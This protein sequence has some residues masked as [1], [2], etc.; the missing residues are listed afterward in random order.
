MSISSVGPAH[1]H[2]TNGITNKRRTDKTSVSEHIAVLD[3]HLASGRAEATG[4]TDT[5]H[6]RTPE[7][8]IQDVGSKLIYNAGIDPKLNWL[9]NPYKE[10]TDK[11]MQQFYKALEKVTGKHITKERKHAIQSFLQSIANGSN[12][13]PKPDG[14]FTTDDLVKVW[15]N[16]RAFFRTLHEEQKSKHRAE[17]DI[18]DIVNSIIKNKG[19]LSKV[20]PKL[21][22]KLADE[23]AKFTGVP[24]DNRRNRELLY[25]YFDYI[26]FPESGVPGIEFGL[27]VDRLK[28]LKLEDLVRTW[29]D[30]PSAWIVPM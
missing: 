23:L 20:D 28:S 27:S 1:N 8:I 10:I 14:Q 26:A 30:A 6:P 24:K 11:E 16:P 18:K 7:D 2:H 29:L 15:S 19:D 5:E 9:V 4:P 25:R 12:V 21:F 17:K 22:K 13:D 3:D